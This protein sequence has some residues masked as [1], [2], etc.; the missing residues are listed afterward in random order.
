MAAF[1]PTTVHSTGGGSS[2]V[3]Y[4]AKSVAGLTKSGNC[5]SIEYQYNDTVS[6][7]DGRNNC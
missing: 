5:Y 2:I 3:D 7:G 1:R 6:N 4:V